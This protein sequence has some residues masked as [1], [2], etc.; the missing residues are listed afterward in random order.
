MLKHNKIH[1]P[2]SIHWT[3]WTTSTALVLMLLTSL[4]VVSASSQDDPNTQEVLGLEADQQFEPLVLQ[5]I[6]SDNTINTVIELSATQDTYVTSNLP[7]DNWGTSNWLRL[8]YNLA[9]PNYGA[10]RI[11][12]KFDLSSIPSQAVINSA[13]FRIYMHTATPSGDQSMGVQARHL[14]SNWSENAVTWNSGSFQPTSP[15]V[16][17]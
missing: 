17:R 4:F 11:F 1:L 12:L 6:R 3:R 7:N 14:V 5:E 13:R 8:G 2:R 16:T 15:G 9:S 10:V